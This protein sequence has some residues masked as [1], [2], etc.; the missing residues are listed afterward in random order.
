MRVDGIEL[1]DPE[2]QLLVRGR[3]RPEELLP[4][5]ELIACGFRAV[6]G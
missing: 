6:H 5:G 4:L 1:P 2:G 3:V